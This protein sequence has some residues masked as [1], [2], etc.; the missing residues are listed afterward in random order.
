[1]LLGELL[2]NL[3]HLSIHVQSNLSTIVNHRE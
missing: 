3:Q 1:M 2:F